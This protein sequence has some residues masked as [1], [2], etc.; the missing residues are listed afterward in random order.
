MEHLDLAGT[1]FEIGL[2]HGRRLAL[3]IAELVEQSGYDPGGMLA[4]LGIA[5]HE[6]QATPTGREHP[7]V[8]RMCRELGQTLVARCPNLVDEMRGIAEGADQVYQDIL[9]LNVG[10]DAE[11]EFLGRYPHCT[12]AG[13]PHT[14]EGAL[15]AKTEDVNPIQRDRQAFFRFRPQ[16]GHAF[17]TYAPAGTVWVDGGVNEAGLG[18]VMTGLGP[19]GPADRAGLPHDLLLRQTLLRCA[20]VDEALAFAEAQPLRFGGCTMTMADVTSDD[21][22]VVENTPSVRAVRRSSSEPTLRTNHPQCPETIA[23]ARNERWAARVGH[24]GLL[25]NSAARL[26]NGLR[27]LQEIPRS[28]EGLQRFLSDHADSGAI[29]Q[30]GQAGLHTAVAMV[31][32]PRE[33]SIIA[34]EGYGCG[35]YVTHTV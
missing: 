10:Y 28:I 24:P 32:V 33:R 25:A 20:T 4:T 7:V 35:Q 16:D 5:G 31:V 12:A 29:C 6:K 11:G 23:L 22:T 2:Q 17:I 3:S 9:L 15:L 34:S 8:E 27:L 13:L 30:H 1:S 14:A 26:Q 18:L 21:I 19:A